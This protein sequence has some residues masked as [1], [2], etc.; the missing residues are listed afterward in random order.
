[1]RVSPNHCCHCWNSP[2]P[3]RDSADMTYDRGRN[4]E[5]QG[6]VNARTTSAQTKRSAL[7]P[8]RRWGIRRALMRCSMWRSV[9]PR[10][11]ATSALFR[12]SVP[13]GS[14]IPPGTGQCGARSV[15]IGLAPGDSSWFAFTPVL[16][17]AHSLTR[18]ETKAPCFA[19]RDPSFAAG[20]ER[21]PGAGEKRLRAERTPAQPDGRTFGD[22]SAPKPRRA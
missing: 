14:R 7:A 11:R 17:P 2:R 1:M 21:R 18:R 20:G 8:R 15:G 16:Y 22:S 6:T 9:T 4:V 13:S 5:G 10:R 12:I 19:T 3:G